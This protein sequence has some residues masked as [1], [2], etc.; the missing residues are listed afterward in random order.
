MSSIPKAVRQQVLSEAEHRCEYC[1]TSSRLIGMPLVIDHITPKSLGGGDERENLAASCYRCNEF[2]GAKT[3]GTDNVS[4]E[5]VILFNPRT[6]VW[7]E[8]FKWTNRATEVVGITSTGRVT[9]STLRLNNEYIIATR[10]IWASRGWHPP[11]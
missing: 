1:L 11:Y 4:G 5:L 6:Q 10:A 8:H 7:I 2:K 9:V 3:Q